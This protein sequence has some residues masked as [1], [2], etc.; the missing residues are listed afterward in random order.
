MFWVLKRQSH[1]DGSF[2]Y[3]QHVLVEKKENLNFRYAVLFQVQIQRGD[4]G[5]GAPL[6]NH[7]LYGFL[8]GKKDIINIIH[9]STNTKCDLAVME[10]VL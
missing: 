3:Q 2:E 4:R 7:K 8:Y 1:S 9:G 5:S 6:E 10:L